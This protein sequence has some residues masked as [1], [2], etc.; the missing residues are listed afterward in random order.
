MTTDRTFCIPE[1]RLE[2]NPESMF[3]LGM[4]LGIVVSVIILP[5]G[6]ALLYTAYQSAV[7]GNP[8][9]IGWL[10]GIL[11]AILSLVGGI[12]LVSCSNALWQEYKPVEHPFEH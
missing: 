1:D 2:N 3:V 11:G 12:F 8:N 4:W 6:F 5:I 7:A 10:L 9:W